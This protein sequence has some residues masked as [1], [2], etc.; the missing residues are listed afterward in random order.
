[1]ENQLMQNAKKGYDQKYHS[2]AGRV[3]FSFKLAVH[4]L[5]YTNQTFHRHYLFTVC[6]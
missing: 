5:Y 2:S 4:K 6:Y 3:D 1:M